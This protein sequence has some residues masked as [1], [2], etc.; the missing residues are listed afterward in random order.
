[1]FYNHLNFPASALVPSGQ[2]TGHEMVSHIF[3]FDNLL[4]NTHNNY[5]E[6]KTVLNIRK[7][8]TCTNILDCHN[9]PLPNISSTLIVKCTLMQCIMIVNNLLCKIGP[10]YIC[11]CYSILVSL[12]TRDIEDRTRYQ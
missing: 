6:I 11:K 3:K 12:I 10:E 1:M 4:D 5:F 2:D 9:C 7:K 8:S